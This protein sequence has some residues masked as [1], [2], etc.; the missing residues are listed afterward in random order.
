MKETLSIKVSPDTKARLQ[1][2][3]RARKTTPSVLLREAL[4]IVIEGT[5]TKPSLYELNRDILSSLGPGGAEDLSTNSAH[6]EGF[7][8]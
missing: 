7:G 5:R 6:L 2:V 8:K 1:S 4:D 3:A